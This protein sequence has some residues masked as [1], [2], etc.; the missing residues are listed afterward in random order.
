MTERELSSF[1]KLKR[2]IEDLEN[3]IKEFGFGVSSVPIKEVNVQSS[4]TSESVQEKKVQLI[5]TWIE[6]RITALEK[7]LEIERHINEVDDPTIRQ[8]MRLRFIDCK[9]WNYIDIKLGYSP[10]GSKVTYYRYR[11]NK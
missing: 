11:K 1:Y 5:D 2:E 8:I 7:C 3:R 10:G 6:K 9:S 4:P